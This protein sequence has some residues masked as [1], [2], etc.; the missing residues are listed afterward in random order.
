[1]G[2]I[3]TMCAKKN[4]LHDLCVGCVFFPQNL[5]QKFY[6]QE[7]WE[8]LQA[9]DCALEHSPGTA[10]CEGNRKTSCSIVKLAPV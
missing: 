9:R 8:M 10:E 3:T 1:M 7:D 5:I 4:E 2:C 6:S